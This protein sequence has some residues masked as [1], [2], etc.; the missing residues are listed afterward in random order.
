MQK[1]VQEK[2]LK[3]HY[4]RKEE[5]LWLIHLKKEQERKLQRQVNELKIRAKI[6]EIQAAIDVDLSF[7]ANKILQYI[8]SAFPP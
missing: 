3:L 4:L 6:D 7:C 1:H 5:E 2:E 8:C